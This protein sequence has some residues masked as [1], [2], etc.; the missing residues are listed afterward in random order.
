MIARYQFHVLRSEA[1]PD[2]GDAGGGATTAQA[3]P[4]PT[5]KAPN[6]IEL[7]VAGLKSKAALNQE[8]HSLRDQLATATHERDQLRAENLRL[9]TENQR[10]LDG[11]SQLREALTTAQG[12]AQTTQQAAAA[13]L[14]SMGVAPTTLPGQTT[15]MP[16]TLEQLESQLAKATDGKQRFIIQKK[17]NA[18]AN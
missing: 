7:A 5:A 8:I 9:T 11:E 17:I 3:A 16:E 15:D 18:L 1:S 13:Q 12:E 14:A 10:L 2:G 6:V 4:E